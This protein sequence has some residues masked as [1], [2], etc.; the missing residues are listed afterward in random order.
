MYRFNISAVNWLGQQGSLPATTAAGD[1]LVV[2]VLADTGTLEIDA[3]GGVF[4][5]MIRSQSIEL[6]A[7][8]SLSSLSCDAAGSE[9]TS[10]AGTAE[11]RYRWFFGSMHP[12]QG[13]NGQ[14]SAETLE[15]AWRQEALQNATRIAS[16]MVDTPDHV[17]PLLARAPSSPKLRIPQATL[18]AGTAYVFLAKVETIDGAG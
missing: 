15:A 5:S 13:V 18:R 17:T 12:F 8:A 14:E 7:M 9:T 1:A 6:G 4:R 16:G 11:L 3:I 10:S 2:E